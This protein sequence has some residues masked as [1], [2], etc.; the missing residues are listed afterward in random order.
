MLALST[1][2]LA[3]V[4]P[5]LRNQGKQ[6]LGVYVW[7]GIQFV[8]LGTLMNIFRLKQPGCKSSVSC[9]RS[10][11]GR[12]RAAGDR[13][14]EVGVGGGRGGCGGGR[15]LTR[16]LSCSGVCVY[17]LQIR[18]SS[19]KLDMRREDWGDNQK[20]CSACRSRVSAL[21]AGQRKVRVRVEGGVG[22]ARASEGEEG[23]LRERGEAVRAHPTKTRVTARRAGA[24]SLL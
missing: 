24:S 14:G 18:S 22:C 6:R 8:M 21:L 12:R 13:R 2:V 23:E 1:Y 7:T 16:S 15:L 5:Q 17:F 4:L 9:G 11:A 20:E 3:Y 10:T 19:S